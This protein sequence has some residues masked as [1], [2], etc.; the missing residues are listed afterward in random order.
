MFAFLCLLQG[1]VVFRTRI[2]VCL[3][4][5]LTIV[6]IGLICEVGFLCCAFSFL[7][8][9]IRRSLTMISLYWNAAS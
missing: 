3:G 2:W 1:M 6:S 4:V 5:L 8:G 9:F 7:C